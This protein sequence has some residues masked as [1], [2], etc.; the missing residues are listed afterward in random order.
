MSRIQQ[1]QTER[2][3]TKSK[4]PLPPLPSV[5]PKSTMNPKLIKPGLGALATG[6][7]RLEPAEI[8]NCVCHPKADFK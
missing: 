7:Q 4:F 8:D 2:T 5:K 3:E 1:E 6:R